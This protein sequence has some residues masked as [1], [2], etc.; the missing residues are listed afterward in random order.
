[1]S[2]APNVYDAEPIPAEAR[3]EIDRMLQNGDLFR[4]TS[5]DASPVALLESEFAALMGAKFALAVS[6][7]SAALFLSLKALQLPRDAK[8]LI[9]AFTFAAVPSAVVHAECQPILVEVSDN[10]RVDMD[11]FAA[12][13]DNDIK[14][15]IISHMRGH[16]SRWR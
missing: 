1:M 2:E 15:V 3:A 5:A 13:L 12:R 6:S 16:T 9:P 11:D 4:Y 10:Y 7:C 8:V 14:A